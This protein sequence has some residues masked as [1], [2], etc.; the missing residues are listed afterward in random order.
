MGIANYI[1]FIRIFISPIFLLVY[2][3][4][5][6]FEIDSISL[7]YFLLFL[8]TVSEMSDAFDGYLARK[9][10][11]VTDFG[12][13]FD[14][15]A[16]SISRLSVLLTFTQE[17]VNLPMPLIFVFLYRDSVISTLRTICALKGFALAARM[18]GKIKALV[19]AVASFIILFLMIPQSLGYLSTADLQSISCWIVA[20]AAVYTVF[21]GVDY[22]YANRLY[23]GR[24]LRKDK[25]AVRQ[26]PA[27]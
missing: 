15:M 18:S 5:D 14:P 12:K 1:T 9:Y 19:Q 4:H 2:I 23:I 26:T 25:K 27:L 8:L 13:I 11:Q 6:V 3:K 10:N 21:S 24:L 20:A 16:D 7:P 17:P 22:I